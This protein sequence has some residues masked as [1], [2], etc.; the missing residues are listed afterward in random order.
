MTTKAELQAI[1]DVVKP[2]T[3]T[4]QRE[5]GKLVSLIIQVENLINSDFGDTVDIDA[6]ITQ[7]LPLYNAQK[8]VIEQ[9]ADALGTDN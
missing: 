2:L 6:L 7:Y 3:V 4:L 9:A 5:A 8:A 1:I